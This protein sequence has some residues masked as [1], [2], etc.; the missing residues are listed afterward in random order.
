MIP[1]GGSNDQDTWPVLVTPMLTVPGVAAGGGVGVGVSVGVGVAVG[2]I[3]VGVGVGT[4]MFFV[5]DFFC[6]RPP[7]LYMAMT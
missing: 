3:G 4:V 1:A 5:P 7:W 6:C 2:G